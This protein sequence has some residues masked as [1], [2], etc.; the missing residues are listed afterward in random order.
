[1]PAK[2]PKKSGA[3]KTAAKN[4]RPSKFTPEMVRQTRFL[5]EKGCTD[6]DLA[7]FFKVDVRTIDNW[8]L[9]HPEFLQAQKEGKAVANSAVV[10]SLYQRAIGYSHSD[11]H[12]S[13]YEGKVTATPYTKHYPPETVACIF[14]LKNR[15]PAEWRDKQILDVETSSMDAF[16]KSLRTKTGLQNET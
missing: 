10:R 5:T 8:K 13:S 9:S 12:F 11:S 4:G 15:L 14:W 16:F 1:M 3:K 7:E 2:P 6:S